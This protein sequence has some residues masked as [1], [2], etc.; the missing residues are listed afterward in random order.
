M[1]NRPLNHNERIIVNR[2]LFGGRGFNE[3]IANSLFMAYEGV[4][5]ARDIP[6]LGK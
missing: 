5:K 2:T 1:S 6:E 4:A 3:A